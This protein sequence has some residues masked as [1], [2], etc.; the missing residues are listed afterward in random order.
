VSIRPEDI[1]T[2]DESAAVREAAAGGR[3]RPWWRWPVRIGA[4]GVLLL[5]LAVALLPTLL[6]TGPGTKWLLGQVN[7]RIPGTVEADDLRL[8]WVKGQSLENVRLVDPSGSTVAWLDR[9]MLA[10]AG[11]IDLLLGSPQVGAVVIEEGRIDL[12]RDEAGRVNLDRALGTNWFEPAVTASPAPPAPDADQPELPGPPPPP[13]PRR[14]PPPRSSEPVSLPPELS[15]QFALRRIQVS[16]SARDV[17]PIHVELPEATLTANGPGDLG[18]TFGSTVTQGADRGEARFVGSVQGLFD[19]AGRLDL[20]AAHFDLEGQFEALPLAAID[21]LTANR[22]QLEARLGPR[23]DAEFKF[24]GG[25]DDFEAHLA[26]TSEHLAVQQD[27]TARADRVEAT[28]GFDSFLNVTPA[29]WSA[30]A[31]PEAPR[32]VTPFTL[33]F[34]V[35]KLNAPRAGRALDLA[36]TAYAFTMRLEEGQRIEVEVPDQGRVWAEPMI[37]L[38]SDRADQYVELRLDADVSAYGRSGR[39]S[40]GL[41]AQK[42]EAGWQAARIDG[43]IDGLPMP[44]LDALLHQGER[45]TATFG[46]TVGMRLQAEADGEG[47]YTLLTD[48][49][50]VGDAASPGDR[51]LHGMMSGSYSA[52]GTVTLRTDERLRLELTPEAF[53]QLQR[54][55]A[56]AADLGESVGMSLPE[57]TTLQA[58]V[59]LS[60]ALLDSPGL[61]FDPS[62]TYLQATVSAP[63]TRLFDRWYDRSFPVRDAS[64]QIEA[65]DLREPVKLTMGFETDGSRGET[66]GAR[67]GR[68]AAEAT[69]NGVMLDDGYVQLERGRV[70]A[71]VEL[72]DLPTV[73]FD[74]LARQRGYAVAA[75]GEK[76]SAEVQI[77]DWNVADGGYFVFEMQSGNGSVASFRGRDNG[78]VFTP[79]RPMAFTLNQTPALAAKIMRWVNPVLLP[80]VRAANVPFTVT[81]DDD[82][83][84][85]PTRDFSFA[86]LDADVQVQMGTVTI[87]PAI[88]PVNQII[89]PLRR[90]NVLSERNTYDARVSPIEIRL[91]DGVISY[92]QLTF[93][94]DDVDLQ[95]GGTI[96]L[97]DQTIDMNLKLAGREIER[98]PLI[99]RLVAEGV[100]IGG[101]VSQPRVSLDGVLNS[102]KKQQ[103]P[104]TLG[105]VFGD[106]LR[107]E[108]QKRQDRDQPEESAP[109]VTPESEPTDE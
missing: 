96:S 89:Q 69:L 5:V 26:A 35:E 61:R 70:T 83:F 12:E 59:D 4:A 19:A 42:G 22:Q 14:T 27:W 51:R 16:Y 77:D 108:L 100:S 88:A 38:L 11:L 13:T 78:Q 106:L 85:L 84:R 46:P 30:W 41:R 24:K 82:T 72:D 44:V 54:P 32:L 109:P 10:D 80:A 17:L 53:E 94:I 29:T 36:E 9:V 21:R 74:T 104:Q 48:F 101:T 8:A 73:V 90:L 57:S 40:T 79:D 99:Q 56:E 97:V 2:V 18:L 6:S 31:G 25:V 33:R 66:D 50:H 87:D 3:R 75:F 39:L 76:L 52:D 81:I 64:L 49:D 107:R 28:E 63:D 105:N 1:P 43:T 93:D 60:V 45:L 103:L 98:D 68:F 47:G 55:V 95:F 58:D 71:E 34:G 15:L 62:R 91:R 65:M 20:P 37:R 7:A 67:A 92:D 23:L 102:F 86:L